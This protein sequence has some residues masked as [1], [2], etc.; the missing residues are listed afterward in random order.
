MSLPTKLYYYF[1]V[2]SE[3]AWGAAS[4]YHQALENMGHDSRLN[5]ELTL[6]IADKPFNGDDEDSPN[7]RVHPIDGSILYENCEMVTIFARTRKTSRSR[8]VIFTDYDE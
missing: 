2:R 3:Y 5:E 1:I 6:L 7:Y 4:K 8:W